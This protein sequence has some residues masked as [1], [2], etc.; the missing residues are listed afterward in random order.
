M[1]E[2]T[3]IREKLLRIEREEQVRIVY[4]CE[5][6]S[7]M[8][9]LASQNSDYDVR[10]VYVRPTDW[11]LSIFDKPDVIERP[12]SKQLDIHGW[13]L[14]KALNLFRKSNPPLFEWLLSPVIYMEPYTVMPRIR[15]LAPRAFSPRSGV[16]HY[17]HMAKRN[18]RDCL[19]SDKLHIKT[20]INAFRP[21]FACRWTLETGGPPPV[22]F[23]TLLE[24]LEAEPAVKREIETLVFRKKAGDTYGPEPARKILADYLE[25]HITELESAAG[26]APAGDSL[27]D[28]EWDALFRD[29]LREVWG[30]E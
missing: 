14:K 13:D 11:Y 12:V 3:N 18:F 9:G 26:Q 15:E 7:R 21:I 20:Y 16:F 23:G 19:R 29:A 27:P 22:D 2:S 5:A 17:L 28:D 1:S 10:F 4:A 6:G 25:R 24:A 30:R 8:W